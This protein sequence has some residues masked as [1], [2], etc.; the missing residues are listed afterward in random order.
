M[1]RQGGG[2]P[3]CQAPI[4]FKHGSPAL[5]AV[6]VDAPGI[7]SRARA[8]SCGTRPSCGGA[9][10]RISGNPSEFWCDGYNRRFAGGLLMKLPH[11]PTS[12]VVDIAALAAAA[13]LL[14]AAMC[15]AYSPR[16][17]LI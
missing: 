7:Y 2:E 12:G 4:S 14:L 10:L 13:T 15:L 6:A 1:M 17:C 3:T 11:P 16:T 5:L 9:F 8:P